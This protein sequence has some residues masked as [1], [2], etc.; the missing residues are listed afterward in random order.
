MR[1]AGSGV[2]S[3]FNSARS[4]LRSVTT[5]FASRND[6]DA[7]SGLWDQNAHLLH[8]A[9]VKAA[10]QHVGIGDDHRAVIDDKTGTTKGKLR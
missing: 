10:R 2:P 3:T 1:N 6:A 8:P 5:G 4:V 7:P 9:G